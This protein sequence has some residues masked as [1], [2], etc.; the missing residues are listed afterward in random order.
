MKLLSCFLYCYAH[1]SRTQGKI[2]VLN[3]G[4]QLMWRGA[5]DS[6]SLLWF[7]ESVKR[8][9]TQAQQVRHPMTTT[10]KRFQEAIRQGA[11]KTSPARS[12]V[13]PGAGAVAVSATSVEKSKLRQLGKEMLFLHS[14]ASAK[15]T[16]VA[17]TITWK[18]LILVPQWS[19][20][21]FPGNNLWGTRICSFPGFLHADSLESYTGYQKH[22]V[23][24]PYEN[25]EKTR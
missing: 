18:S 7:W 16:P 4:N 20:S 24:N 19:E 23:P 5:R 12:T 14:G 13:M 22:P 10:V 6:F 9:L 11:G 3:G 21:S 15:S 8:P 25:S 2:P 17:S 1:H